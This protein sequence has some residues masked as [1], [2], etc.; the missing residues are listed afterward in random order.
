MNDIYSRGQA[1]EL[2]QFWPEKAEWFVIGGPADGN[3]AQV[4]NTIFGVQCIGFEPNYILFR[5]QK[6]MGFP[7]VLSDKALWSEKCGL[8]LEIPIDKEPRQRSSSVCRTFEESRSYSV[9]A[10][11]LDIACA[12]CK[13]VVLWL[14]VE[15][16]E[17]EILKGGTELLKRTLLINLESAHDGIMDEYSR[18]LTEFE[19]IHTW[20][21]QALPGMCDVVYRRKR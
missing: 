13:N 4:L 16:A 15:G 3:E 10:T 18:Y 7:G 2:V 14:D 19:R 5:K 21:A 8:Y 1:K 11:T 9:Q 6:D 12:H 17:M 20:N